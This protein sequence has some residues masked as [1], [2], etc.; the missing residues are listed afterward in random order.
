[1]SQLNLLQPASAT[2]YYIGFCRENNIYD[3]SS[4]SFAG[5]TLKSAA[6]TVITAIAIS[7]IGAIGSLYN[8]VSAIGKA[9]IVVLCKAS[10]CNSFLDKNV[11]EYINDVKSHLILGVWDYSVSRSY[12]IFAIAFGIVPKAVDSVNSFIERIAGKV[13]NETWLNK[14]ISNM[15]F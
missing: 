13:S 6:R 8:F 10:A 5:L 9:G 1:M 4:Y 15:T 14:T 7:Y 2:S 12:I 3:P 11:D